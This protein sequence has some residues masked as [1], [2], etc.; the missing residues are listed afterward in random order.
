MYTLPDQL[1][2]AKTIFR[3]TGARLWSALLGR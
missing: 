3:L 1:A 2:K